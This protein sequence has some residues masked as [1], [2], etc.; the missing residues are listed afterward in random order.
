LAASASATSSRQPW[1]SRLWQL[2]TLFRPQQAGS[3]AGSVAQS[4]PSASLQQQQQQLPQ[5]RRSMM[6]HTTA[7]S[8]SSAMPAT[9]A[10]TDGT[11]S[12]HSV[13]ERVRSFRRMLSNSYGAEDGNVAGSSSG[14]R[15]RDWN[16]L[17]L[18][19]VLPPALTGRAHVWHNQLNL[20][21]GWRPYDMPYFDAVGVLL[22]VSAVSQVIIVL[23]A[24]ACSSV[25]LCHS[26]LI[27]T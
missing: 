18:F 1:G 5:Q 7:S 15:Q 21:D 13:F 12:T 16:S 25:S 11:L 9:A 2:S 27:T 23:A 14:R 8:T 3:V 19:Q 17:R 6:S 24:V 4:P 22:A 20:K 26:R 10:G